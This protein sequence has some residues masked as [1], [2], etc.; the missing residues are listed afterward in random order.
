MKTERVAPVPTCRVAKTRLF[1]GGLH[2]DLIFSSGFLFADY[3]IADV[4]MASI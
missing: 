3:L 2:F 4:G 1:S